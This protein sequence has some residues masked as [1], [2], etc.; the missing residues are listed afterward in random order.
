MGGEG[1]EG[2]EGE[3]GGRRRARRRARRRVSR[4]RRRARRHLLDEG[5]VR[6][7]TADALG[8]GDVLDG[9]GLLAW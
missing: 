8:A 3:G 5:V 4:R 9:Q 7:A 2:V 6:V 1:G